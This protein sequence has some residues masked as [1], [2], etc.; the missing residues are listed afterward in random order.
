MA[1][2]TWGQTPDPSFLLPIRSACIIMWHYVLQ[3]A[4]VLEAGLGM[5][6]GG[7]L[8]RRHVLAKAV[9]CRILP[10]HGIPVNLPV[11][12][13]VPVQ[14]GTMYIYLAGCGRTR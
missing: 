6:E 4:E 7:W 8:R 10:H 11:K 2:F 9:N 3:E 5:G 13:N 12:K 14:C 1:N